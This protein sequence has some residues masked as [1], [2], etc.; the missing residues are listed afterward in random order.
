M[1]LREREKGCVRSRSG[2]W[3][4]QGGRLTR[5]RQRDHRPILWAGMND[6]EEAN[7]KRSGITR[8]RKRWCA[9]DGGE[10]EVCVRVT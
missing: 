8:K 4:A 6:K 7:E 5:H 1:G 10:E 3:R 2:S 9:K